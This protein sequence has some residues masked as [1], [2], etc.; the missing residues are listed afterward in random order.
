METSD[1]HSLRKFWRDVTQK[2]A[3][4]VIDTLNNIQ[5][6][7]PEEQK[8]VR[9]VERLLTELCAVHRKAV[10][11]EKIQPDDL[12]P[13]NAMLSL[14]PWI[15]QWAVTEDGYHL[16]TFN[17][18][19][20]KLTGDRTT[21]ITQFQEHRT[22]ARVIGL[23]QYNMLDL[24]RRCDYCNQWFLA[25]RHEWRTSGS[26]CRQKHQQ[27]AWKQRPEWKEAHKQYQR[28]Y[29]REVLS[30]ITGKLAKAAKRKKKRRAA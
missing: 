23:I 10:A 9:R 19:V 28:K 15:Q 6:L 3:H 20:F 27:A 26:F 4:A 7:P 18:E 8:S 12:L 24:V 30:P 1:K 16:R 17:E 13:L 2:Y 5:D 21:D 14:Y 29:Y 11:G 25:K 22:A